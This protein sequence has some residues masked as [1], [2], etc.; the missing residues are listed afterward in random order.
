MT[1]LHFKRHMMY[2]TAWKKEFVFPRF[3]PGGRRR[4]TSQS[5]GQIPPGV[6]DTNPQQNVS[7]SDAAGQLC[8]VAFTIVGSSSFLCFLSLRGE[9][10]AI[11]ATTRWSINLTPTL[12]LKSGHWYPGLSSYTTLAQLWSAMRRFLSP[13]A[14]ATSD[15]SLMIGGID[16]FYTV[17]ITTGNRF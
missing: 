11:V 1:A 2:K 12:K 9:A 16:V 6:F 10:S 3:I 7:G 4:V 8:S 17:V 14:S 5:S 15:S 13:W